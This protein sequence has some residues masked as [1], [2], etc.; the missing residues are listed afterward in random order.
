MESNSNYYDKYQFYIDS[1]SHWVFIFNFPFNYTRD[2]LLVKEGKL[3]KIS[4]AA[5]RKVINY[6]NFGDNGVAYNAL[7]NIDNIR[8]SRGILMTRNELGEYFNVLYDPI[9]LETFRNHEQDL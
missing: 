2:F 4:N 6:W 3:S 1:V 7:Y 5:K 8:N 9:P